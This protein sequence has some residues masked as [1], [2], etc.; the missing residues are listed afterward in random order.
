MQM[1]IT[2]RG[3][4]RATLGLTLGLVLVAI[5]GV[6]ASASDPAPALPAYATARLHGKVVER[7]SGTPVHATGR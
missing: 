4:A 5:P 7:G 3:S 1:A 2:G 6:D